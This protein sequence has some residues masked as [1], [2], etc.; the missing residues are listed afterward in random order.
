L[1]ANIK[2]KR[3]MKKKKKK[4]RSLVK[5]SEEHPNFLSASQEANSE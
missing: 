5:T 3:K 2:K 4:K 1:N